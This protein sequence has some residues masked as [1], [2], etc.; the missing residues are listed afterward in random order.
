[1]VITGTINTLTAKYADD[2]HAKGIDG[3][4]RQFNHPY[5]QTAGMFL[6]EFLCLLAFKFIVL[7]NKHKGMY[8]DIYYYHLHSLL[9]RFWTL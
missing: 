3:T 8:I 9:V 2:T 5:F 1:M 7:Y 4:V 6:G